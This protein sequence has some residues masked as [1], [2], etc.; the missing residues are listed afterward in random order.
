MTKFVMTRFDCTSELMRMNITIN[1]GFYKY[2]LCL[3]L[4]LFINILLRDHLDLIY[5]GIDES[6]Y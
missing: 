1:L 6:E 5:I 3:L 2:N 4:I